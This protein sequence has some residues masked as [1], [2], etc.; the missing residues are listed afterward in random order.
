MQD[1][2]DNQVYLVVLEYQVIQVSKEVVVTQAYLVFLVVEAAVAYLVFL[3]S[4][5]EGVTQAHQGLL[6]P[7]QASSS[8]GNVSCA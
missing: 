5:G 1:C 3:E 2:L 6:H 7:V 8:P 4:Q